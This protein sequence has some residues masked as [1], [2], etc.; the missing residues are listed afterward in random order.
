MK[1]CFATHNADKAREVQEM[2]PANI[3]IL[4]LK[5]LGFHEEI[6]ENGTTIRENALIKAKAVFDKLNIPCF[7]DDTGLEVFSLNGE[8]GVF[9]ARYAGSQKDPEANMARLL[10]NLEGKTDRTAQFKTVIAYIGNDGT[11]HVFEGIATGHILEKKRGQQGFGYDPVFQPTGF[12][13]SFAEMS[14]QE[15]NRISHRA[16]AFEKLVSYLKSHSQ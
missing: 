11:E 7:A 14:T 4:D 10:G 8:P 1:I 5:S 15:K 12:G 9:S 16:K 13:Q 6:E 2:L 3:E